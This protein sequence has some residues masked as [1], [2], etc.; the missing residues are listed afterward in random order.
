MRGDRRRTRGRHRAP[1]ALPHHRARHEPLLPYSDSCGGG[2][3]PAVMVPLSPGSAGRPIHVPIDRSSGAR[4][5]CRRR[6][7]VVA[8]SR[9]T[10]TARDGRRRARRDGGSAGIR[11]AVGR[12]AVVDAGRTD[13][14]AWGQRREWDCEDELRQRGPG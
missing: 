1:A 4:H 8:D 7:I 2:G 9:T 5:R 11:H 13:H 10:A 12:L 14:C 3:G 6:A